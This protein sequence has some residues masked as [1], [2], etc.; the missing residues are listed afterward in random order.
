MKAVVTVLGKDRTGIIGIEFGFVGDTV[1]QPVESDIHIAGT[2]GTDSTDE[3]VLAAAA[4]HGHI[5]ARVTFNQLGVI[6]GGLH[7]L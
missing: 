6:P 5:V 3:P 1:F 4:S 2:A 7:L